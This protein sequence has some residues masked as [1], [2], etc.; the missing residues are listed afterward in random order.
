MRRVLTALVLI[1]TVAY[2]IFL[3]PAWLFQIVVAAM[4]LACFHEF[5]FIA[6]SQNIPVPVWIGHLAGMIFLFAPWGDWRL[7]LLLTLVFLT[8]AMRAPQLKDSLPVA[9]ALLLGVVYVYGSW[10]CAPILREISPWW[11]FF[12][13]S[14]NWVGDSAAMYGGKF[15]GK[16]KLAP[17]I[18]PGKTWEGAISSALFS[19]LYGI[20]LIPRVIPSIDWREA[21][22]LAMGA[23]IA[24][25][26][27]DL[28]ESALKRGANVKDSGHMLPGHGGWLDRLDSTLFSMPVVAL[29]LNAFP[30]T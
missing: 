22:V 17:V 1:P 30:R 16:H 25:Q 11:L 12:A 8:G 3:G 20:I 23:C 10:R 7:T 9:S 2:V 18:S 24:G 5:A 19:T 15:F 28:A 6:N 27:G 13:V 4:G 21:A 26:I 14:I 29:Y